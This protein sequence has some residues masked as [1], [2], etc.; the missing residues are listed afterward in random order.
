MGPRQPWEATLSEPDIARPAL[1]TGRRRISFVWLMP[2]LAIGVAGAVVYQTYRDQGPLITIT[3]PTAAGIRADT[4]ELR[5][6]DLK[7]GLVEEV[8]FAA[9]MSAVE[10]KVRVDKGVAQY[11][12][13]DAE[14]WLVQPQVSARGV[15]GIGTLLSGV[16]IA[17]SWDGIS[18]TPADTFEALATPPLSVADEAGTRIT[19]RTR[20]GGQ[21][22]AG[23]P[24]LASGIEVGRIGTPVLSESGSVVTMDAFITAPH[25]QRLTANTRFWDA[26]GLTVNVGAGGLAV[27]V[28]SLA[29]LIEGGVSFGTPVTGGAAIEPGHTFDVFPSEGEARADAFQSGSDPDIALSALLDGDVEGLGL[30]TLVRFKGVK[31]GEV[32]DLAG[33]ASDPAVGGPVRLRVDLGVS[34]ERLGLAEGLTGDALEAAL[35]A[36]VAEGLR[37]RVANEGILGQ[38]VI[39]ELAEVTDAAPATLTRDTDGR[40]LVPTAPTV[41]ADGTASIEGLVT[42]VSNLPIEALMTAA[43]EALSNVSR[44]AGTAEAVLAADGVTRIPATVDGTLAEVRDLV[45]EIRA[46]GAVESLNAALQAA[47]G[48]LASVEGA[49]ATLPGLVSRLNDA[50]QNLQAVVDGYSPSSR[51]YGD[52]REAIGQVSSTAEAFRSL[53]RTI[54][55]NPNSLI[56]GR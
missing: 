12:D 27:K 5:I 45:A 19:L 15:T 14:F 2:L 43:T 40:R 16:Y 28:D 31:V 26:S 47:E 11:I 53:A 10:T 17:A 6:R 44:V 18:G 36:R 29:A 25:D 7:V 21:L 33:V 37:L 13:A 38:T 22:A 35:E 23:A 32:D 30:G 20:A 48:T 42:R 50:A 1:D 8:G 24:V 4:T 55:R 3:F 49:V 54:E 46:G 51:F 34:P 9:G 56:T 52:L 39:L 41:A